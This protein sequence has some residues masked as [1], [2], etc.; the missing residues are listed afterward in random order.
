MTGNFFGSGG[1]SGGSSI[2]LGG[3]M[4]VVCGSSLGSALITGTGVGVMLRWGSGSGGFSRG[5]VMGARY[6][7][8]R[9]TDCC[10]GAD[11]STSH[12][13]AR[14]SSPVVINAGRD[15]RCRNS[16]ESRS[17]I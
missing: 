13:S 16:R 10:T 11:C 14:C 17:T 9:R 3:V 15:R 7:T 4:T 8:M 1:F 5:K 6:V 2:A 12:S